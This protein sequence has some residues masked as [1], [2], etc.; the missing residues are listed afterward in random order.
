MREFRLCPRFCFIQRD[1]QRCEGIH[2]GY[3]HGACE[4]KEEIADY[5][6]RV[7]LAIDSLRTQPSY[8]IIEKGLAA[9]DQSS[10]LVCEGKFYGMAYLPEHASITEPESLKDYITPYKENSFIRNIVNGYA[11]RFPNKVKYFVTAG[12]QAYDTSSH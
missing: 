12:T 2:E 6:S 5:N 1:E 10:I 4:H 3:C 8:A 11:A 7:Q 9:N